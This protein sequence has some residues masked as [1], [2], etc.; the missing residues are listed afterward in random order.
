[1][2]TL[3]QLNRKWA[4][5]GEIRR[6]SGLLALLK[7][8]L[9]FLIRP[10]YEYHF[11]YL[12]EKPL[13]ATD[14]ETKLAKNK[15]KLNTVELNFKVV[16]SN[17]EAERLEKE[18]YEFRSHSTNFNLNHTRYTLLLDYG[19]TAFCTFK[20]KE[21]VAVSWIINSQKTQDK[22]KPPP[23]AINYESENYIRGVWC[24]PKYR[25]IG[26]HSYSCN[27]RDLYLAQMGINMLRGASVREKQKIQTI[28]EAMGSRKYGQARYLKIL[29]WRFWQE[30]HFDKN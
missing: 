24:H 1:L 15:S 22:V 8:G 2:Y 9:R 10:V 12:Y 23:I 29:F 27:R 21:F 25:G 30:S 14:I 11:Y 26:I 13:V 18:G 19:L 4:L 28:A 5:G 16:S 6:D 20:E 7:H 17:Q 3:S